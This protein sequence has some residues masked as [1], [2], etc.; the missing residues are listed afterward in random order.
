MFETNQSEINA[1]PVKDGEFFDISIVCIDCSETF[2][3]T[4]G[5]QAFFRDKGLLNPPKR[6]KECKKAKTKR[7][8]AI[9]IGR[10]LGKRQRIDVRAKCARCETITTVPFY[11]SQGRP[12][13]CR[14]CY[15]SISSNRS[16]GATNGL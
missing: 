3:F 2:V 1:L 8:D 5:E 9:E 6:C 10:L 12:V 11:P 14:D 4:S 15:N 13:Y 16:N 7:I